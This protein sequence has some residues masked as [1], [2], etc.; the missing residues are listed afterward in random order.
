MLLNIVVVNH[1]L[2]Y[3]V[4]AM[5]LQVLAVCVAVVCLAALLHR[6]SACWSG[7]FSES[8]QPPP[9]PHLA[10]LPNRI[11]SNPVAVGSDL[12]QLPDHL[13]DHRESSPVAVG[14]T[15]ALCEC[16][17]QGLEGGVLVGGTGR[18]QD[19]QEAGGRG[20][21]V[22]VGQVG[23]QPCGFQIDGDGG[24]VGVQ[25]DAGGAGSGD[26]AL[27]CEQQQQA[28]LMSCALP[29]VVGSS[30]ALHILGTAAFFASGH[31][32]EFTGLQYAAP[33]IGF[34]EVDWWV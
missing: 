3:I 14:S 11:E 13:N 16:T 4:A 26:A 10:Q 2:S 23:K 27:R 19:V 31:F 18:G 28:H 15:G 8:L 1:T 33:F 30:F 21:G 6:G 17:R 34:D 25:V 20:G 29:R 5:C 22:A 24:V 32:C 7:A 12:A 9:S